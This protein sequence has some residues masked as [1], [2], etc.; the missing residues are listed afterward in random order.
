MVKAI[1]LL[2]IDYDDLGLFYLGFQ[3]KKKDSMT[4]VGLLFANNIYLN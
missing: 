4:F 3:K 1:A 2:K